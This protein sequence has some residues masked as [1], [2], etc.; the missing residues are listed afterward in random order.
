M[1]SRRVGVIVPNGS[2]FDFMRESLAF[3]GSEVLDGQR[4]HHVQLPAAGVTGV[5][6]VMSDMGQAPATLA[7]DRLL[8]RFD[9]SL[10]VLIGTAASL[11]RKMRLGDVVAADQIQEYLRKTGVAAGTDDGSV[12][13]ERA[14]E[15]WRPNARL[16][17]HINN[18]GWL[19][20]G[21]P[22]IAAWKQ[23]AA[24]RFPG[25]SGESGEHRREPSIH[26]GP[27]ATGDLRVAARKFVDWI[28]Q[29]NRKLVALEMEAAGAALAAYHND[30]ADLLVVRGVSDY[31]DQFKSELDVGQ[32]AAG[33]EDAWRRYAV[34]NAIEYLVLLLSSSGF[35][36]RD[37]PV[38]GTPAS[39]LGSLLAG[40]VL[41]AGGV[42]VLEE[43]SEEDEHHLH[44]DS[45]EPHL[46]GEHDHES[47]GHESA[48]PAIATSVDDALL[49]DSLL[50]SESGDQYS[51]VS[52]VSDFGDTSG[53]G[54][55]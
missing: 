3:S 30:S 20:D 45:H 10:V 19:P 53:L 48:D 2:E 39:R 29:G 18:F 9:A 5:V 21:E 1:K 22:A 24:A 46:V 4:Y 55:G 37:E 52:D 49:I 25:D 13:F 44:P 51:D 14:T 43:H 31:A 8:S 12:V 27:V 50:A 35:P 11:D 17:D 36:W 38:T 23:A 47:H 40:V 42:S 26:V 6:R 16:V 34:R 15:S 41:G 7:A 33:V 54:T 28:K 32:G